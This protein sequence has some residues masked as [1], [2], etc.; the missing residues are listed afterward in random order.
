MARDMDNEI[1]ELL[2]LLLYYWIKDELPSPKGL[3]IKMLKAETALI[4][5]TAST[6]IIYSLI[7]MLLQLSQNPTSIV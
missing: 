2:K 1:N 5:K 3:K 4:V 7:R 6:H